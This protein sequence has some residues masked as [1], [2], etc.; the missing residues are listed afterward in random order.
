MKLLRHEQAGAIFSESLSSIESLRKRGFRICGT[1]KI[2]DSPL[3]KAI[4]F[5]GDGNWIYLLDDG[6]LDLENFSISLWEKRKTDGWGG[7]LSKG[8]NYN[9]EAY[10]DGRYK[11]WINDGSDAIWSSGTV[12]LNT[13]NL[14]TVTW[15][16][17]SQNAR[18]YINGV[19]DTSDTLTSSTSTFNN[20]SLVFSSNSNGFVGSMKDAIIWDR[21]LSADE[22][23]A[24]Y[25]GQA[26]D[27]EKNVISEWDMSNINPQDVGYRGNGNNGTQ[28]G[29]VTTGKGVAGGTCCVFDGVDDYINSQ[30]NLNDLPEDFSFSCWL[31]NKLEAGGDQ[32]IRAIG[33][34]YG[35]S[36]GS[37][38]F[39]I[40]SN[41]SD[42][43]STS[44][45]IQLRAQDNSQVYAYFT[46]V[47][48]TWQHISFTKEGTTFKAY[49]N[50]ELLTNTSAITT[51]DTRRSAPI[52][53]GSNSEE[54]NSFNGSIDKV[55]VFDRALTQM[56]IK[57]LYN[58]QKG[59]RR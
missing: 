17:S 13:W 35:G 25:K 36:E 24:L 51:S 46:A 32:Y 48:N 26:F 12:S 3:G 39:A 6:I 45:K 57:D 21:V 28:G 5:D 9:V 7:L 41:S 43:S 16:N 15:D 56:E 19:L 11:F 47:K 37:Y 33:A 29:G 14:V 55:I 34:G 23:L 40:A 2:V 4:D 50:G 52:M 18:L 42:S 8:S 38:G 1:P 44:W 58:R 49:L 53:I 27:Y 30:L 10:N 20:V 54:N 22:I 59:G 31:N